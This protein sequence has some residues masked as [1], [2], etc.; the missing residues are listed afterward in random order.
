MEQKLIKLRDEDG[1]IYTFKDTDEM[2]DFFRDVLK[3]EYLYLGE[4]I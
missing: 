4:W 1:E 2:L 3:Y